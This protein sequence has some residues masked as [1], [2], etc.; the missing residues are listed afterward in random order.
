VDSTYFELYTLGRLVSSFGMNCE[1]VV[2]S[3]NLFEAA[4]SSTDALTSVEFECDSF[5]SIKLNWTKMP[6][7][8]LGCSC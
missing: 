4:G 5:R 8:S 2:R 1:F 3:M 7:R 6:S